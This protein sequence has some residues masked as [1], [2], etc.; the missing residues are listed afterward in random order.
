[1]S[2]P[3]VIGHEEKFYGYIVGLH[4][5]PSTDDLHAETPTKMFATFEYNNDQKT[6]EVPDFD[7][8][9]Q[10]A[11]YLKDNAQMRYE[12]GDYGYAKLWIERK[13]DEWDVDLP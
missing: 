9:C 13:G 11:G 8:F 10:L 3:P 4:L 12:H 1:M 7:L 2:Q 6:W 5:E